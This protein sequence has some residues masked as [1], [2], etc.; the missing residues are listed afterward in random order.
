MFSFSYSPERKRGVSAGDVGSD[1]LPESK[2]VAFLLSGAA[3][4]TELMFSL[5]VGALGIYFS[6]KSL[7]KPH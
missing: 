7:T 4:S 2:S 3:N 5:S 6:D 1:H